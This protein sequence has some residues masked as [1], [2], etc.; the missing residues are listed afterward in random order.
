MENPG[1]DEHRNEIAELVLRCARKGEAMLAGLI[2]HEGGRP[3]NAAGRPSQSGQE[4]T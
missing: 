3:G 1:L 4:A 2:R